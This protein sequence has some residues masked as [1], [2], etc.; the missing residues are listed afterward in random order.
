MCQV[1]GEM[2]LNTAKLLS[3][4]NYLIDPVVFSYIYKCTFT[5]EIVY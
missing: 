1:T 2:K 3:D 4:Q 5:V